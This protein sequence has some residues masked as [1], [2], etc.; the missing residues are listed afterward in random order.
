ML[1]V[2][3]LISDCGWILVAYLLVTICHNH[4]LAGGVVSRRQIFCLDEVVDLAITDKIRCN[5][6]KYEN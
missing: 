3:E 6:V 4:G 2:L 5:I 1:T